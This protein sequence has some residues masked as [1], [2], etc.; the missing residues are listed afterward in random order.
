VVDDEHQ[1]ARVEGRV[2]APGG[3][4]DENGFAAQ[5]SEKAHTEDD[6]FGFVTFVQVHSALHAG[7]FHVVYL[8]QGQDTCVADNARNGHFGYVRVRNANGVFEGVAEGTQSGAE[9]H[10]DERRLGT[11]VAN[12]GDGLVE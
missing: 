7:D 12:G 2:D 11:A 8:S 5:A 6:A 9:H 4:G 3:V 10:A 1:V